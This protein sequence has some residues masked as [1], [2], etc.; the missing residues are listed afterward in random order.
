MLIFKK[1]LKF[2]LKTFSHKGYLLIINFDP[3]LNALVDF[4]TQI[5]PAHFSS[6]NHFVSGT[7]TNWNPKRL[8]KYANLAWVEKSIAIEPITKYK[9]L[10][11][12]FHGFNHFDHKPSVIFIIQYN[13]EKTYNIYTE[14][15]K[16]NIPVISLVNSTHPNFIDFPIQANSI[17]YN[18]VFFYLK[19]FICISFWSKRIR[20]FA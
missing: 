9:K 4:M 11:K 20:T 15:Q 7:L 2:L 3:K 16:L 12:R 1:T 17:C 19:A 13:H 5:N 14:A 18:T 6:S 10:K 8:N